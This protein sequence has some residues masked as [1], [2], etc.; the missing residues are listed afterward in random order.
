MIDR[1]R[2]VGS[3][4]EERER[5]RCGLA[6]RASMLLLLGKAKRRG[7]GTDPSVD[8]RSLTCSIRRAAPTFE[9]SEVIA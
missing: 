9:I 8:L 3:R 1:E 5:I 6:L 7:E 4:R 2:A